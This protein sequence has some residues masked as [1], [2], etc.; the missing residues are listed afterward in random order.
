MLSDLKTYGPW[1]LVVAFAALALLGWSQREPAVGHVVW[2]P[3]GDLRHEWDLVNVYVQGPLG[4][5]QLAVRE[6]KLVR[7][8][9]IT[10]QQI[11]T[12]LDYA[13]PDSS[14]FSVSVAYGDTLYWHKSWAMEPNAPH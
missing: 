11:E 10:L 3:V 12:G 13:G 2:Q 4:L 14:V 7:G 1:F 6:Y 5:P 9:T 8:Y